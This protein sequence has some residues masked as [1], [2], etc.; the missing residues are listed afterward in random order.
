VVELHGITWDHPRGYAPLHA[1]IE[2]YAAQTGVRVSWKARSLKDFGDAPIDALA[3]DFDLLIIDHPHMGLGLQSGCL[4][5]LDAHLPPETLAALAAQS[6]GL[7]HASYTYGG[8]QW[9]LANDA[10][11]QASAYRPDLLDAPFPDDW[12]GVIRLGER[13]RASGRW[14]AVPLCPTDAIC[15]FLTLCAS[16]G[17]PPAGGAALVDAAVGRAALALLL[18]FARVAHP[19][20]LDWNPIRMLD[21]MSSSGEIAYCPLSFCYTNYARDGYAPHR[22]HFRTIP[23]VKGAI[24][25]GAGIAVSAYTRHPAEACAYAAWISSADVQ[26]GLY[27]EAG[28][29]PGNRLAWEDDHANA[30]THDFFR[31]TLPTLDAA[32]LRPRWNGWHLFQEQAGDLLHA[33]LRRGEVGAALD[34]LFRLYERH[35]P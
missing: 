21:R 12:D 7:S 16:L 23:G 5:P 2:Q 6:A 32:Y 4:L 10:A 15:S 31:D 9:A 35:A 34:E 22:V 1:S 3:R 19:E 24:L 13:V 8:H 18:A 20:S 33:M 29:Q 17:D 28:G 11:M 27:V 25:G 26:R 30:L 14:V